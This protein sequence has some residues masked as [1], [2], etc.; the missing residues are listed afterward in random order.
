[1]RAR[2]RRLFD[3]LAARHRRKSLNKQEDS[4]NR[5]EREQ[6]ASGIDGETLTIE[7]VRMTANEKFQVR[8]NAPT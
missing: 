5:K 8:E 2:A 3:D 7:S 1:M 4:R 6:T